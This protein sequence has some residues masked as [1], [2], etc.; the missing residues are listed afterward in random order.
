VSQTLEGICDKRDGKSCAE[1]EDK[2]KRGV[3][4][5]NDDILMK[6]DSE[7]ETVRKVFV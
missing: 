1:T 5:I 7:Y 2:D 4:A 3:S 6:W